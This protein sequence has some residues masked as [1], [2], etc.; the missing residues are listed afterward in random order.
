[1]TTKLQA[2][3]NTHNAARYTGPKP[4]AGKTRSVK[5][6]L[7]HGLRSTLP[8][9]PDELPEDWQANAAGMLQSLAP[10]AA[11]GGSWPSGS[12]RTTTRAGSSTDPRRPLR[13]ARSSTPG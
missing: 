12:R 11:L 2:V 9:L 10:V 8:V 6:S 4:A 7:R 13:Y 5:N 1:M 3:A